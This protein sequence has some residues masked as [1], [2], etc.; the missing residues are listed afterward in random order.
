MRRHEMPFGAS[1][2]ET[3]G[4][5]FALWAP[6]AGSLTLELGT[7]EAHSSHPMTRDNAGWHRARVPGS[8]GGDLYRYC[9]PDG[10]LVPDPASR[11]NPSDVHGP[12]QVVD[13]QTFH[14]RH[15]DF[16]GLPWEQAVIYE[17][18]VGTFSPEGTF[19]A[20]EDRLAELRSLGITAIELM[21]VADFPGGRNWGYDG[22]L[23][24][25]P[26]SSYGTPDNLKALVDA[27]HGLGM[28]M[29]LDVV[30]NHFGPDGNYLHG[31]CPEF[32][33]AREKT[34]WGDAINYDGDNS[35]T[36]RDYFI[37]NALY[38][39]EE[40]GFDGLRID[41]VHAIRDTSK[42]GIIQEICEAIHSGPGRNRHVHV[43]LEND[44][45]E[46][47]LLARAQGGA[48][49]A[50]T[51]QW[52]DDL[53][54]AA[55][56]LITGEVDGYYQDYA[57]ASLAL[58]GRALA[59]GFVYQGQS[60]TFRNGVPR[61]EQSSHLPQSAF[62]SFLQ[63]HDQVGNRAFGDRLHAF[64]DPALLRAAQACLLLSPHTPMLFMGEEFAASSPFLFFC[65]FTGDLAKA[66][67]RGRREEFGRF[68]AFSD[69]GARAR[70]PDP[71][72][73]ST[74][75]ASKLKWQER[76]SL[77][78]S[79]VLD[80]IRALLDLRRRIL[81]PLFARG[82]ASG[83]SRG[84]D[85]ILRVE[86]KIHDAADPAARA[87]SLI[88]NFGESTLIEAEGSGDV[89]L[90]P[91]GSGPARVATSPLGRGDVRLTLCA[92]HRG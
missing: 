75:L 42:P 11:R 53:H 19:A 74:F 85:S 46:A 61:G 52:N 73:L 57:E 91:T 64:G 18:H 80:E 54:H 31:Y 28:M 45:N 83:T 78:H 56:V 50:A 88:A 65:D 34:P 17:L 60:S 33:N 90:Y 8:H 1:V 21:P 62:V 81:S 36:V 79:R 70:I 2:L 39:T 7:G 30:Y 3:G 86:W 89:V 84:A 76:D 69:P 13:P 37:H 66:V 22:V 59:E 24:F 67:A 48:L 5:R 92:A 15:G 35:R 47:S 71:N 51:A 20:V 55:H 77:P 26:D 23:P 32:F 4:V 10:A 40:F 16:Q 87:L 68:A 41:A 27:A 25:A 29:I 44:A 38:W 12:S 58:F 49:S 9:L 72:A 14:W 82:V 6:S 43:I 63:T